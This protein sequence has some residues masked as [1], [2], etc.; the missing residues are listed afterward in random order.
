MIPE[1]QLLLA[2]SD[3]SGTGKDFIVLSTAWEQ[4]LIGWM[5]SARRAREPIR[6]A[7]SVDTPLRLAAGAYRTHY[8]RHAPC[9]SDL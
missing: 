6:M 5:E 9:L 7:R 2:L 4:R 3:E 1:E 8:D